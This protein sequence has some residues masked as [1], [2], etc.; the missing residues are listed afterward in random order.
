MSR[1][2]RRRAAEAVA[3]RLHPEVAAI[4]ADKA[5]RHGLSVGQYARALVLRDAGHSLPVLRRGPPSDAIEL[6]RLVAHIGKVGS[7][8]N[9]IARAANTPGLDIDRD[10]LTR[11]LSALAGIR[12]ALIVALRVRDP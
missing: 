12:G 6:R 7:N 5:A 9:Q 1:S 2:E 8:L 10:A 11:A 3:F 4:A